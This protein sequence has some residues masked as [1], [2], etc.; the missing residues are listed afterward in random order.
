M[1]EPRALVENLESG[2]ELPE[3]AEE[4]FA[5]YGVMGLPFAS[6]HVLGLRRFPASSI[7]PGYTSL[8][9]RDAEGRWSFYQDVEAQQ[10]CPR[11]F[12]RAIAEAAQG[13]VEIRWTGPRSFSVEVR[14]DHRV[15]WDVSLASSPA[16]RIMSFVGALMP[17]AMWR[18][19][20]VLRAMGAVASVALGAG[21]LGLV[22]TVPNGQAF[23]ANPKLIWFIPS[24]RAQVDGRDLGEVGPLAEQERL[25]DFWI[26]QRGIFVI[27]GAFFEPFDAERHASVTTQAG[28]A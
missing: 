4:R 23:S 14:G 6:G 16:T 24:S 10:S 1:T 26:P 27:G 21:K 17:V 3:G 2:V 25:G 22:G 9:H 5:G 18:S 19:R 20:A 11:Y 7:G 8:W 28:T 13:E 15:S 12:G